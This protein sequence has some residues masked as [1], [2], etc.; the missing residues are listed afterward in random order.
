MLRTLL[1]RIIPIV[2]LL[3]K[4]KRSWAT[5]VVLA[6]LGS[7]ASGDVRATIDWLWKEPRDLLVDRVEAARDTQQEAAQELRSA[8]TEFKAV[9]NFRGGELEAR[10][11]TLDKA[12]R[13]SESAAAEIT[14]RVDRVVKASNR[15]LEEWRSELDQYNDAALRQLSA[16]QFDQTRDQATQL[17]ASMRDSEQKMQPVLDAFRDQVLYLKH[18]LNLSAIASLEGEAALIETDV[19]ALIEEMNRSIA[20][21]DAFI[22]VILERG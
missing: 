8:L 13:R 2:P 14:Q 9:V 11:N 1:A 10:Y 17:I 12:Y 20:E 18:N 21:A 19:D 15:L 7:L 16:Q 22:A 6:G 4:K 3:L 5:L